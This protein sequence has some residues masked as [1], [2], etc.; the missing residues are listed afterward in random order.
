MDHSDPVSGNDSIIYMD[1][2][3]RDMLASGDEESHAANE[4]SQDTDD[5]QR[6]MTELESKLLASAIALE[7]W[8][9]EQ[10]EVSRLKVHIELLE[11]E[12]DNQK[13]ELG[14]TKNT[15]IKQKLK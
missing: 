15:L 6:R 7:G 2:S 14:A 9:G 13:R 10:T 12:Y 8:E 5:E 1:R 11:T 3:L 4:L